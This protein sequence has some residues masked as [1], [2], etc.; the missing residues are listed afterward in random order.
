MAANLSDVFGWN[1]PFKAATCDGM[2]SEL[3]AAMRGAGVLHAKGDVLQSRV[4]VASIDQ[5]LFVHSAYPTTQEDAVF[6]GPDTYRFT[7]FF[8]QGVASMPLNAQRPVRVLDV[9]LKKIQVNLML[10]FV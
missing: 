9:S 4:R 3:L 8:Q 7:R 1:L 6:F 2:T 10:E 5:D